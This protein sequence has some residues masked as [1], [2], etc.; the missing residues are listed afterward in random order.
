MSEE[1]K[2]ARATFEK[3]IAT[4]S[5]LFAVDAANDAEDLRRLYPDRTRFIVAPAIAAADWFRPWDPDTRTWGTPFIRGRI[6]SLLVEEIQ[7]PRKKRALLD[8]L[9][10]SDAEK[11]ARKGAE[12]DREDSGSGSL[13]DGK[14]R[15][16]VLLR[17]GSR[18][19]PWVEEV[20]PIPIDAP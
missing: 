15:Y 5:R 18:H 1:A 20:S 4:R 11:A 12:S 6:Q 10:R 13:P 2:R 8:S 19:D 9:T 7:V 16:R 3:E 17:Y 14:P